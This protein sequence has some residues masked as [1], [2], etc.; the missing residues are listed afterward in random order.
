MFDE[1]YELFFR[2]HPNV[3]LY[4]E[5]LVPHTLRTYREEAWRKFYVFDVM[6]I[7]GDSARYRKPEDYTEMLEFYGIDYIP[8]THIITNPR[9]DDLHKVLEGNT[10]LMQ[11]GE[12]GEGIVIKNYDYVNKYGRVTWAKLVRNEFKE[13]HVKNTGA[14]VREGTQGIEE[15]IVDLYVTKALVRKELAKIACFP[16]F[17][18]VYLQKRHGTSSRSSRT[19]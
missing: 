13:R 5:W 10:Y 8:C 4:G 17:T 12:I 16:L 3:R 14:T 15:A 18:I 7:D 1:R 11:E 2:K 19:Q 6:D 9:T